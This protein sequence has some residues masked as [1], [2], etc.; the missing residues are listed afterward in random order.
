MNK[1]KTIV[2]L[3][4][5][6]T[7]SSLLFFGFSSKDQVHEQLE[8]KLPFNDKYY[9]VP[10]NIPKVLVFAEE[11]VPIQNFD[12]YESLDRE[13]LVNT[14]WQS[15]TLIFIKRAHRYFPIIEP[16][17]KEQ[18]VP[19]DFKYLAL[20]ES[21]LANVISPSDAVGF[22][23]FLNGTAQDYKLEVN[24]EVDERYH[25]EKATKA[26]AQ[27]LKDSHTKYGSWAMAAA[28]YN[29]G[30]R[31][32]ST[33]IDRQ[34]SDNYYDLILGEE[35][36]RY[37]Y[38]LIALKLILESPD[39]YGFHVTDDQK[40]QEIPFKTVKVDST[41]ANLADF[42]HYNG[43]NYKILKELNPWLRDVSLTNKHKKTYE[44]KIA[45]DKFRTFN[46]NPKFFSSN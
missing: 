23:Q 7:V 35:T 20:A 3:F 44:I 25:L 19:D 39:E 34:K 13:L 41:I 4:S 18:G 15:Q 29:M 27:F 26:A 8:T 31:N 21:G 2:I 1:V 46:P 24:S 45:S 40:Y 30:R 38:R 28:S 42:A 43:I 17:L 33:Q 5:F 32:V 14:Y 36:G 9:I 16:I 11:E 6:I 12:T 10:V 22:W 37:M